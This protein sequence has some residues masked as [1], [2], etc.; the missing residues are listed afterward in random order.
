MCL[1]VYGLLAVLLM[2]AVRYFVVVSLPYCS[3]FSLAG[4]VKKKL[5]TGLNQTENAGDTCIL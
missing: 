1:I 4:C 5:D 2:L 3:E